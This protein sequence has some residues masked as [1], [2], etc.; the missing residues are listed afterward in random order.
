MPSREV[1]TWHTAVRQTDRQRR[2]LPKQSSQSKGSRW[3]NEEMNKMFWIRV[4][5]MKMIKQ[6]SCDRKR[7]EKGTV[8]LVKVFRDDI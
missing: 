1:G 6:E 3:E 8:G 5:A 2:P 4:N 7:L